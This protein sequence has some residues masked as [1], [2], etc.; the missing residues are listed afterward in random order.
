MKC[1]AFTEA[2]EKTLWLKGKR[3]GLLFCFLVV[4]VAGL[5]QLQPRKAGR[6]ICELRDGVLLTKDAYGCYGDSGW[7]NYEFGF[8][9]KGV[10]SGDVHICAGFRANNRDDRYIVGLKGGSFDA[11]YLERMG[12]MG[13]DDYLALRPLGFPVRAGQW[14]RLRVQ[15][16]GDRMRVYL[17]DEA[18]PRIDIRDPNAALCPSGPLTLGGSYRETAFDG[19]TVRQLGEGALQGPLKEWQPPVVDK[20]RVRQA[21]RAAY[22]PLRV[23]SLGGVRTELSLDG[24]WLFCPGY[25]LGRADDAILPSKD[26]HSWHVLHVP[27]F[28]NP[29]R[30]WLHGEKYKQESKGASDRYYQGEINRCAAYSYD[31]TRTDIGWYRQWIELPASAQG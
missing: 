20:E 19:L 17:G 29:S 14:Y 11:L 26:D 6:G 9:A 25:E 12:Y 21:E 3:I 22:R 27:D 2:I 4:V 5:G 7:R 24:N 10:D 31:Y 23:E 16:A 8:R 28:W 30:V 1:K 15:V 13:T 18:L